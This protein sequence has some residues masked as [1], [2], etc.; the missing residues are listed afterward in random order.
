MSQFL[1]MATSLELSRKRKS[2]AHCAPKNNSGP[3]VVGV[4]VKGQRD[5]LDLTERC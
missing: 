5:I 1:I 3:A 4:G 2:G